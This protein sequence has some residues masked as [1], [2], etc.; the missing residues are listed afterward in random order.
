MGE[1]IGDSVGAGGRS[2]LGM[3]AKELQYFALISS[4]RSWGDEAILAWDKLVLYLQAFIRR[5][6]QEIPWPY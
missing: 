3:Q 6:W 1:R 5:F 4:E 2:S